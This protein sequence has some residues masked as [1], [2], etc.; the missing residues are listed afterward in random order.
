M[1]IDEFSQYANKVQQIFLKKIKSVHQ[2]NVIH[3]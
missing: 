3:N 2:Q 1:Y